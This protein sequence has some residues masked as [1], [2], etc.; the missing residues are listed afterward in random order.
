MK[1]TS[2][3]NGTPIYV[4]PIDMY[5]THAVFVTALT[6]H[7]YKEVEANIDKRLIQDG[8]RTHTQNAADQV[9]HAG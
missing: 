7:I 2:L 4:V 1:K 5:V 3:T 8:G 9:W 6:D